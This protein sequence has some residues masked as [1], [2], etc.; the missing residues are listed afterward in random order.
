MMVGCGVSD[1]FFFANYFSVKIY[2][3]TLKVEVHVLFYSFFGKKQL[4][5]VSNCTEL[6]RLY[7]LTT[8]SVFDRYNNNHS[9]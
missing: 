1:R 8:K 6:Y 9:V 5:F 7:F 4:F 2:V 3:A